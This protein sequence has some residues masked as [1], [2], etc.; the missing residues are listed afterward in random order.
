VAAR[1]ARHGAG[2]R[3]EYR[4]TTPENL[5]AAVLANIGVEVRYPPIAA[6]GARTAAEL[7]GN[8]LL[9]PRGTA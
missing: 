9:A 8:L 1:I 3:L 7:L 4:T 2:T 5:A 6:D